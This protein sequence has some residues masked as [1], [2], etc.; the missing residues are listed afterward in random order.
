M[1]VLESSLLHVVSVFLQWKT[2]VSSEWFGE[3]LQQIPLM[4]SVSPSRTFFSV[5]NSSSIKF[6]I[7]DPKRNLGISKEMKQAFGR[8][9]LRSS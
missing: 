6:V 5:L 3:A 1:S 2:D 9:E 8:C 7:L 4:S